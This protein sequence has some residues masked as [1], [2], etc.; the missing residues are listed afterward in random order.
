MLFNIVDSVLRKANDQDRGIRWGFIGRLEDLDYA[1]DICFLAH[2]FEDMMQ[3]L[4]PSKEVMTV[5]LR[6]NINKTKQLR[7]NTDNVNLLYKGGRH[8][9]G[10]GIKARIQKARR[11]FGLLSRV[12]SSIAYN[13]N[14]KLRIFNTN[15]KSVLLY[16]CETWKT[17]K[18]SSRT[19]Q[20]FVNK[21]AFSGRSAF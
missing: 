12:W 15:V 19:L 14:T 5:G 1:D 17:T 11:A 18:S 8:R 20:V 4:R 13:T 7:V 2:S 3:K 6:I 21:Y 10:T 16:G 9:Y